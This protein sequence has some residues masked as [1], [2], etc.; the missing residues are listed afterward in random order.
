MKFRHTMSVSLWKFDYKQYV[1]DTDANLF[2]ISIL[3]VA[4][5]QTCCG[6]IRGLEMTRISV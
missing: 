5:M 3:H 4:V 2:L 1:C 6:N